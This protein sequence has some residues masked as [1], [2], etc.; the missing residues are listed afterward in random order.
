MSA[1]SQLSEAHI[2]TATLRATLNSGFSLLRS[3]QTFWDSRT[4][5]PDDINHYMCDFIE[6]Y[7][8]SSVLDALGSVGGLFAI[9]AAWHVLLF[10]RPLLWGLTGKLMQHASSRDALTGVRFFR[11]KA[12]YTFWAVGTIQHREI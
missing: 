3:Q 5:W 2:A 10:G 11:G 9:L 6:D 8:S 12:H 1:S 7:R 4:K